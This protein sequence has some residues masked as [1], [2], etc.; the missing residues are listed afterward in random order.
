MKEQLKKG[1]VWDECFLLHTKIQ[2]QVLWK[3][4]FTQPVAFHPLTYIISQ[5]PDV[6]SQARIPALPAGKLCLDFSV[7]GDN[8]IRQHFPVLSEAAALRGFPWPRSLSRWAG[9]ADSVRAPC[10]DRGTV[11]CAKAPHH[12]GLLPAPWGLAGHLLS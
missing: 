2:C 1:I 7:A 10:T 3:G 6:C 9:G 8:A 4:L 11:L 12:S 5:I